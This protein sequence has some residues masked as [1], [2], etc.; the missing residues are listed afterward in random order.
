MRNVLRLIVLFIAS[1]FTTH[2]F[3]Q[4]TVNGIVTIQNSFFNNQSKVDYVQSAQVDG[5]LV[6]IKPTVTDANGAFKLLTINAKSNEKIR[7]KI[8]KEG[9][10]VVNQNRLDALTDQADTVRIFIAKTADVEAARLA[11]FR[12]FKTTAESAF[13]RKLGALNAELIALRNK[14]NADENRVLIVENTI[15][16]LNKNGKKLEEIAHKLAVNYSSINLDEASAEGQKAFRF[17]Q[18]NDLDSALIVL[19]NADLTIKLDFLEKEKKDRIRK[20]IKEKDAKIERQL[21]K[22]GMDYALQTDFYQIKWETEQADSVYKIMLKHDSTNVDV[23]KKYVDFLTDINELNR[24]K[25]VGEKGLIYAQLSVDKIELMDKLGQINAQLGDYNKAEKT[26]NQA[27]DMAE[28]EI[29]NRKD[30]FEPLYALTQL[31]LGQALTHKKDF[32]NAEYALKA[33][34]KFHQEYATKSPA[35]PKDSLLLATN[36]NSMAINFLQQNNY[37]QSL[38]YFDKTTA[39]Y[40][41][42]LDSN[43][44]YKT[45]LATLKN[46]YGQLYLSQKDTLNALKYFSEESAIYNALI[47]N[48]NSAFNDDYLT[49][50]RH[51]NSFYINAKNYTKAVPVLDTMIAFQDPLAQLYPQQYAVDLEKTLTTLGNIYWEQKAYI[52]AD[53]TLKKATEWHKTIL[54]GTPQYKPEICTF[55]S[56]FGAFYGEQNKLELA[57]NQYIKSVE[58][59]RELVE[60]EPL[61]YGKNQQINLQTIVGLHDTLLLKEIFENKIK[62]HKDVQN[63]YRNE[64]V[65]V[66][67]KIITAY[68]KSA[69]KDKQGKLSAAYGDLAGYYLSL[70][71]VKEAEAVA[72]KQEINN[73]HFLIFIYSIQDKFNEAQLVLTKTGDKKAA[74]SHCLQ[75]ANDFYNQRIIS[76]AIKVKINKWLETSA[77]IG[78][79]GN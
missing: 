4:S 26:L 56:R 28:W 19:K 57:E 5:I 54:K 68:E 55:Y 6:K 33:A 36:F 72:K 65:D 46:N 9:Y 51:L 79:L 45:A 37:A 22:I 20:Q 73:A 47:K 8:V 53:T 38:V 48:D 1:L 61:V 14:P 70:N 29:I 40:D 41:K 31:R 10:E 34:L 76:H 2:L 63:K 64:L 67:N 15:K 23:H 18:K 21:Q 32:S 3:A 35:K 69:T 39:I 78:L 7:L 71:K 44:L 43:S 74:K 75:W 62:V 52:L 30:I 12:A 50:L 66:Q 27:T 16:N 17:F 49:G 59:R 24:A 13:K 42:I 11:H 58:L 25:N 60:K 77:T